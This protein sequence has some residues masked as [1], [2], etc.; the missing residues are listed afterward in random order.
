MDEETKQKCPEKLGLIEVAPFTATG[1]MFDCEPLKTAL[2]TELILKQL[3]L[4]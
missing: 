3:M 4:F 1:G 2:H